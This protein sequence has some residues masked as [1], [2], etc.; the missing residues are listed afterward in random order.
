[1]CDLVRGFNHPIRSGLVRGLQDTS[2]RNFTLLEDLQIAV[3][4]T[5]LRDLAH[6]YN[7]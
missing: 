2:N 5:L 7:D 3:N 4:P 6:Y 1:M